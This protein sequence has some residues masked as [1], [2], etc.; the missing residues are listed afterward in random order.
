MRPTVNASPEAVRGKKQA[1]K[2]M[3][4][5][6]LTQ[7]IELTEEV[8]RLQRH[9]GDIKKE[10]EGNLQNLYIHDSMHTGLGVILNPRFFPMEH[11][12]NLYIANVE[13]RIKAKLLE[14]ENL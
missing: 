5:E 12:I 9:I 14:L 4:Q 10:M 13:A 3:K 1:K 11:I 2:E 6:A 8:A 7:A